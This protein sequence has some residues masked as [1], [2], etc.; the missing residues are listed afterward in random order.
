M[1]KTTIVELAPNK[2]IELKT[3][4]PVDMVDVLEYFSY[5][6]DEDGDVYT[7]TFNFLVGNLRDFK[8][9]VSDN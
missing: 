3:N 4:Y 2:K 6:V 9:T 5:I 7:S 8:I 1:N